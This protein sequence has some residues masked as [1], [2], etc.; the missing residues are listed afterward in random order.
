MVRDNDGKMWASVLAVLSVSAT[1][2]L[3]Y[4]PLMLK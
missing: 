3:L 1:V 2:G 4:L